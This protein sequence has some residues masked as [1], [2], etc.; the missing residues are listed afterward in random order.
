[1]FGKERQRQI[2]AYLNKHERATVNQLA[3]LFSVSKETIRNDLN[4]LAEQG[5]C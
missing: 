4:L 2:L 1:M 5:G 3:I